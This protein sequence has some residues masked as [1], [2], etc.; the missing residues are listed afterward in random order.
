MVYSNQFIT[1]LATLVF[2]GMGF[3]ITL[4]MANTLLSEQMPQKYRGKALLFI[5]FIA[6]MG[7]F[8]AILATY[9]FGLKNWRV[10]EFYLSIT[11]LILLVI[12]FFKVP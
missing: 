5:S 1:F 12:I 3:G 10:P 9:Y 6:I 8:L 11:G 4:I 2:A 7:K